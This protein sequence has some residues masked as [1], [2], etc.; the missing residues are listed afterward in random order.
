[1]THVRLRLPYRF[2][3]SYVSVLVAKAAAWL[4]A[5]LLL[6]LLATVVTGD[7]LRALGV[8]FLIVFIGGLAF[9]IL[10]KAGGSTGTITASE[11]TVA[12]VTFLG[13]TSIGPE[14]RFS[15]T[16]F[17]SICVEWRPR[18][19]EPGVQMSAGTNE[20]IVLVGTQGTPDIEIARLSDESGRAFAREL[21]RLLPLPV[22]ER[23]AAG[24]HGSRQRG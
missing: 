22:E 13:F 10:R 11:I 4:E 3:T 9:A 20:T 18:V 15:L 8:L 7:F 16:Q 2:D 1:M 6:G 17:K 14:G 24:V 19:L 23:P 12:R 5:I 21:G